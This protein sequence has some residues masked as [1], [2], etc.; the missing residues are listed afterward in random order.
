MWAMKQ[1]SWLNGHGKRI[2]PPNYIF[3]CQSCRVIEEGCLLGKKN[4]K[5]QPTTATIAP[6]ICAA[7][8]PLSLL[9]MSIFS[10][11]F[12]FFPFSPCF[13]TS[14][15]FFFIYYSI[16]SFEN[17]PSPSLLS[18]LFLLFFPPKIFYLSFSQTQK[19]TH[20]Q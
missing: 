17:V 10:I 7:L 16:L 14:P 4:K 9:Q 12:R 19:A 13:L 1:A 8:S 20:W 15:F 6:N 18:F 11:F 2:F 3:T 5:R